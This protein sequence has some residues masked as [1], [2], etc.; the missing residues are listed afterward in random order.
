[1]IEEVPP[2]D[3]PPGVIRQPK[4]HYGATAEGVRSYEEQLIAQL[5]DER[6]R[7]HL[8]VL[9]LAVLAPKAALGLIERYER[10]YLRQA[11][12]T[13]ASRV[14]TPAADGAGGLF[15]RLVCE[16]D[17]LKTEARLAWIDYARRE[18]KALAGGQAR[19]L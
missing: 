19:N 9:Q 11:R 8:F 15:A 5:H 12:G 2:A 14:E 7:S 10:T 16:E 13:P 1:L 4:P 17:R 6:R 3:P 18:L